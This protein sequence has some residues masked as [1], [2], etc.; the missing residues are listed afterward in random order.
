M[1]RVLSYILVAIAAMLTASSALAHHSFAMF[2]QSKTVT[3]QGTVKD[4]RWTNPHVFI[5]VMVKN[6]QG[7]EE[8]W[9][10]EM[11]SPEHLVRT[12][13]KPGTL[14]PGDKITLNI[15][16][17]R[18]GNIKGGQYLNGT[19]PDGPLIGAPQPSPGEGK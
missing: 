9:S 13:W 5:Q 1:S 17:L 19:G 12:G 4:F 11:T 6:D 3:I 7:V 15:H 14:K 8:E 10:I 18:D 16:P 2:D